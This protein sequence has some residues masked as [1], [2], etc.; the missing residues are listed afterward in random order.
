M[1]SR[2]ISILML[3]ISVVVALWFFVFCFF[4]LIRRAKNRRIN[5]NLSKNKRN[6]LYGFYRVFAKTPFLKRYFRKIRKKIESIYPADAISVNSMAT[7]QMLLWCGI[8]IVMMSLVA[9]TCRGDMFFL[10]AGVFLTYVS[11]SSIITM[12]AD[13]M[14][15]KLLRQL[16]NFLTDVRDYYNEFGIVE[17]AIYATF[18]TIPYEISLH[19]E[20]IYQILMA[21]D[22][23]KEVEKYTETAPNRFFLLFAAIA[24]SIKEN[25]DKVLDGGQSLFLKNVNHLAEELNIE[26]L[27]QQRNNYLFAGLS[28]MCIAPAFFLKPIEWW[29]ISNVSE[30]SS[31]YKSGIGTIMMVAI[32]AVILIC[33]Q[34]ISNLKDGRVDETKENIILN[35][36]ASTPII[37]KLLTAE[38][39]RNYSKTLRISDDLNLVG[40]HISPNAFLLKRILCAAG[41]VVALNTVIFMINGRTKDNVLTNF[42]N[43]FS[44]VV[45]PRE[46]YRDTMIETGE[47]YAEICTYMTGSAEDRQILIDNIVA[48]TDLS[49]SMAEQVADAVLARIEQ[50]HD[51]YYRSY[52]ILFSILAA[53]VGFYLPYLLLMYQKTIMKMNMEDEVIQFQT[54]VLILMHVDGTTIDSILEWMERFARSFKQTITECIISLE[55]DQDTAIKA[56]RE[57]ETFPPF[58]KFVSCLL[59]I[60]EVGIEVAFDKV[61]AD[62]T[63]YQQKRKQDNEIIM[64]RKSAIGKLLAVAPTALT[65]GGYLIFPFLSMAIE[66]QEIMNSALG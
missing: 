15:G 13:R 16:S 29:G 26:I 5:K 39:N 37:N 41:M 50:Y 24:S 51:V 8:C 55:Y 2:D 14:E 7:K 63:Y 48:E 18:E 20:M 22:V 64:N 30:L 6:W 36:L 11:A 47:Y 3:V 9:M 58:R 44:N 66:M 59:N 33:Y 32:F 31:F 46:S 40:D 52:N 25:G 38:I 56:M 1:S 34:M 57:K 35:K 49:E 53:I 10:M 62:R 19:I 28:F 12:Q 21:D 43:E 17:D 4:Y 65:V 23:L 27:K 45:V 54:L 42:S 60:D 61:E